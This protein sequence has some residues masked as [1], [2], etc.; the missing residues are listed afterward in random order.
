MSDR[1]ILVAVLAV[2]VFVLGAIVGGR[3]DGLGGLADRILGENGAELSS[4]ALEAIE[5]NYF[6]SVDGEQVEQ[7]SMQGMIR[8]LRR[9]YDDRF[10]HY[11][12]PRTFERFQEV[13]SGRFSGVGLSVTEVPRGLRIANVFE[14]SPAADAGVEVGDVVTAVNG[15][16]IAGEDAEAATA[17]IKGK[18]GTEVTLSVLTPATGKERELELEREELSVPAVEGALRRAAGEPVAYVQLLTFSSGVHAELRAE[19]ERL[20]ERG[21][22]GVVLDLR[23]NGGGLLTEAVL[24]SSVFIED[25]PIVSTKGRTQGE[26][27]YDAVGDALPERPL[28][29]LVNGDTASASEILTAAVTEAGLAESV[30]ERTF[31]K[32]TFQEVIPL[33]Q[34]GALDLTVGEYLTRD[35]VSLAG[36]GLKPDFPVRDRPRTRLDEAL[37]RALELLGLELRSQE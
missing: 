4:E 2:V 12:D 13:T 37:R 28:V 5:D 32:G 35:G 16:G 36:K 22:R 15:E 14:D 31:G 34:G 6:R 27:G 29:V 7:A 17:R 26:R 20:V 9:R 24:S 8:A 1:P 21:A 30:G 18:S 3:S 19:I 10:S 23:G 25:G 11:F 33:E